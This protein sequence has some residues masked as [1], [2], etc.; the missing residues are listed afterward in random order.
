MAENF[1]QCSSP[2]LFTPFQMGRFALAHRIV[3]A[4]CTRCRAL[5]NMPQKAHVEY[6]SQ[7]ATPGGLLIT[8]GTII[9]PTAA[10]YPNVPGIF[11][12]E[13]VEA[14]K[15]VV[16]AVHEKGAVL[17]CQLWHVG[18]ASHNVYQPD[19]GAPVSST[20]KQISET[21]PI[22]MPDGSYG[23]FS[24]PQ[25]LSTDDIAKYVDLYR[26]AAINAIEA[27]FD[28]V[29]I[30]S[31]HGYL[32]DQFLKDGINDRSDEYGGSIENRCR[33]LMQIVE[34]VSN[35]VGPDRL[36]IRISPAF[37]HMGAS[38]SDP[39]ALG[40]TIVEKLN[41]FQT[42]VGSKLAYLHVTQPRFV[43]YG[44][45]KDGPIGGCGEKEALL[46]RSLRKAYEGAFLSSGGYTRQLGI[47]AVEC[48]EV[49][50]VAFGRLFM[51]NPDLVL[52]FGCDARLN[53][54]DRSTFYT[55]DPVVGYT[56]YPFME[57]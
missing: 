19:G 55:F 11:T 43:S 27:G 3:L 28:G 34:A 57:S 50:L 5:N 41:N 4:P 20:E 52:R 54:Y 47:D 56:D 36:A 23:H 53:G 25:A 35:A 2:K 9:D 26:A 13:Q 1:V 38:D 18:R 49:D 51:A 45:N 10:G 17:F 39:F 31:A 12:K 44:K 15:E 7:R 33:F 48:G 37:D 6:Y 40:L 32:I 29:E 16:D 8:E 46:M 30:H 14:W 24:K 21:W 42:K 22:M